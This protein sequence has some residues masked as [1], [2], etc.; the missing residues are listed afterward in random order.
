MKANCMK[1]KHFYISHDP[2]APRACRIYQ[3]KSSSIPSQI[4][5]QA[6]NGAECIGFEPKPQKQNKPKDLNDSRYW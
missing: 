5:K 1:C 3:I 6:N 4:V 2:R